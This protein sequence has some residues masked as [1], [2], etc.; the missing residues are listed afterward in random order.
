MRYDARNRLEDRDWEPVPTG[1]SVVIPPGGNVVRLTWDDRPPSQIRIG[2]TAVEFDASLNE[3]VAAITPASSTFTISAQDH[4]GHTLAVEFVN[5]AFGA[6]KPNLLHDLA[7]FHNRVAKLGHAGCIRF[8]DLCEAL[9]CGNLSLLVRPKPITAKQSDLHL[10]RI[11][12]ALPFLLKVVHKP[13]QHLRVDEAVR[14]VSVVRRSG[15]AALRHLA[16]HSEHWEAR[17]VGGLRPERLLA[18]VVEDDLDLYENRF[19]VTLTRELRRRVAKIAAFVSLGLNQAQSAVDLDCYAQELMDHRVRAVLG[20]LLPQATSDN[21]LL[22]LWLFEDL[23]ER[24]RR[25]I[26]TLAECE[27]TRLYGSLKSL[28]PVQ[29]PI[30]PT[31]IL[32]MD[33]DYRALFDLWHDLKLRHTE[34]EGTGELPDGLDDCYLEFCGVVLLAAL[35]HAGFGPRPGGDSPCLFGGS[36]APA[37]RGEFTR[38][39]WS[40]RVDTIC[41]KRAERLIALDFCRSIPAS[42]TMPQGLRAPEMPAHLQPMF[43]CSGRE[44][45]VRG[46]AD[47]AAISMLAKLLYV[48]T[49]GREQRR[50]P[51]DEAVRWNSF[52]LDDVKPNLPDPEKFRVVLLPQLTTAGADPRSVAEYSGLLLDTAVAEAEAASA[53]SCFVLFAA[54]PHEAPRGAPDSAVRRLLSFGDS[55]YPED[56]ARWGGRAGLLP[57]SPWILSS[58]T[59]LKRVIEGRTLAADVRAARATDKCPVCDC[60][61]VAVDSVS[62]RYTAKCRQC[63]SLWGVTSCASCGDSFPWLRLRSRKAQEFGVVEYGT[64]IERVESLLGGTA[65]PSFCES[66]GVSP[67]YFPLCPRCGK[68]SRKEHAE[69]CPRCNTAGAESLAS[70]NADPT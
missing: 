70:A 62:G 39:D 32:I 1:R 51:N 57:V 14:P 31:N 24:V 8:G 38:G 27:D 22:D 49:R 6:L 3:F 5:E 45:H 2:E 16:Q 40:V 37:V 54:A 20:S 42:F 18:Q 58:L 26:H 10:E 30:L 17:T 29:D 65:F 28:A 12:T 4:E 59:H 63:E 34:E 60:A 48:A 9:D 35:R 53:D 50:G 21:V 25:I 7:D 56:A 15:P 67:G 47:P 64:R 13:R 41:G 11:A 52:I 36:A 55:F 69:D 23:A 43:G 19:V 46:H 66:S 44:L 68:C 61:H 33:A